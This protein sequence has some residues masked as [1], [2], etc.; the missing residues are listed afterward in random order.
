MGI[1]GQFNNGDDVAGGFS[2]GES[3]TL[4][5]QDGNRVMGLAGAGLDIAFADGVTANIDY[6]A[7]L[8]N[9]GEEHAVIAGVTLEW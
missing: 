2:N 8:S 1:A 6:D 4:A 9:D 3:F 7:Q 5:Q